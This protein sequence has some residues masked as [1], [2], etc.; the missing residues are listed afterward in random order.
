MSNRLKRLILAALMLIVPL[1]AMASVTPD[2]APPAAV[3]MDAGHC[4]QHDSGGPDDTT[5]GAPASHLCCLH[6]CPAFPA[7]GERLPLQPR[8][9]AVGRIAL[10]ADLFIPDLPQRPPRA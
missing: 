3:T 5:G 10:F 4:L 2:P 1:Q 8:S 9:A 7:P 6:F